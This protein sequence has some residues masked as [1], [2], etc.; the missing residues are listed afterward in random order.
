M[1]MGVRGAELID[2]CSKDYYNL[3]C[4]VLIFSCIVC[5]L[6]L[7]AGLV[8]LCLVLSSTMGR[9]THTCTIPTAQSPKSTQ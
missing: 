7:G 2:V 8:F 3:S 6:R 4:D 1:E 9:P 5:G